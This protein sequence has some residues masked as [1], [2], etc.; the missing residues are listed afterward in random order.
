MVRAEMGLISPHRLRCRARRQ[1]RAM[2]PA[3]IIAL[4]SAFW[5]L[6]P[7]AQAARPLTTDDAGVLATG[8]CEWELVAARASG[9]G[10]G[11]ST[12]GTCGVTRGA[13]LLATYGR[14]REGGAS[15]HSFAPALKAAL[16]NGGSGAT[17]W[18]ASVTLNALR[19][20][21][22]TGWSTDSLAFN[23]IATRPLATG[24]SAHANLGV[25]R[26]RPTGQA[27][28][29]W[30]LAVERTGASGIDLAA[31]VLGD[32]RSS[33]LRIGVGARWNL[34]PNFNLNTAW[35]RQGGS[36]APAR[37]FTLGLKSSF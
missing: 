21:S 34:A 8:D 14:D 5:S 18:A 23:L 27:T 26:L 16:G 10:H 30:S 6:V 2:K 20:D 25:L 4:G 11:W 9:G 1:S 13:Q 15:R 37:L 3:T 31:E 12:L 17:S 35:T 32:D 28:T 22:G 24:Y 19:D 36:A 7:T 33:A 29:T